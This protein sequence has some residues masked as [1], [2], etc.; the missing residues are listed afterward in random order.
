MPAKRRPARLATDFSKS[1]KKKHHADA[2]VTAHHQDDVVET[3]IINLV[4]GTGRKGLTALAD[5]P[6][7]RRPLLNIPK[8]EIQK[9][10]KTNDLDWREDETNKNANICGHYIRQNLFRD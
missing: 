5:R 2:I 8:S 3:A 4:R 10:A 9:Y 6:D 1:T 7:I